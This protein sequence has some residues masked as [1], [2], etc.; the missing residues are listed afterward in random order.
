MLPHLWV[1]QLLPGVVRVVGRARPAAGLR[2]EVSYRR[3]LSGGEVCGLVRHSVKS[4]EIGLVGL[5]SRRR[6]RG[7]GQVR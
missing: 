1:T 7:N 5:P 4:A 6:G 3:V 2:G